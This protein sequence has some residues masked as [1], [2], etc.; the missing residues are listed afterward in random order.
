M[1]LSI[2]LSRTC[3]NAFKFPSSN[4]CPNQ[5][6]S[7]LCFFFLLLRTEKCV[8]W[9][10]QK[11]TNSA[12]WI[13]LNEILLVCSNSVVMH[14]KAMYAYVI[15]VCKTLWA[16][17]LKHVSKITHVVSMLI[18]VPFKLCEEVEAFSA[19]LFC[20]TEYCFTAQVC[21]NHFGVTVR[22]FNGF[23]FE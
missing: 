19:V 10:L 2:D 13:I 1:P 3:P 12:K 23:V 4:Q 20:F 8:L 16:A 18:K 5:Y 21:R 7:A 11:G 17:F 14:Q 22:N 6:P 15:W 9:L